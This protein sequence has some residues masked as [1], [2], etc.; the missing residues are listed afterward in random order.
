MSATRNDTQSQSTLVNRYVDTRNKT[1]WL[2]KQRWP[3]GFR[4]SRK[5]DHPTHHK[6]VNGSFNAKCKVLDVRYLAA[7]IDHPDGK[8]EE[9]A[10]LITIGKAYRGF[11]NFIGCWVEQTGVPCFYRCF[12][13]MSDWFSTVFAII[14]WRTLKTSSGWYLHT[15]L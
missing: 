15:Y 4:E 11:N 14:S 1:L 7:G 3:M 6:D 13:T 12:Q 10:P 5:E 9:R 2:A 8:P